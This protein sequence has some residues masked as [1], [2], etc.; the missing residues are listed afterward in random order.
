MQLTINENEREMLMTTLTTAYRELRDQIADTD[1]FELREAL[2]RTVLVLVDVL[3]QLDPDWA[4]RH[5]AQLLTLEPTG[6]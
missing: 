5:R 6:A 4:A 1:A 2:K 3:E